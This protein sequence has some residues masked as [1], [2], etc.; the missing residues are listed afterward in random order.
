M[1]LYLVLV[2]HIL[3]ITDKLVCVILLIKTLFDRTEA[4][5]K[6]EKDGKKD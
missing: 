4:R 6:R 2:G 5:D 3:L 1:A